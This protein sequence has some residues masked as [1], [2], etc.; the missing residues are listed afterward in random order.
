MRNPRWPNIFAGLVVLAAVCPTPLEAACLTP[1]FF[2]S[3]DASASSYFYTPG[4]C[5][6]GYPCQGVGDTS[7]TADFTGV[8]WRLGSGDPIDGAGID[9]GGFPALDGPQGGWVHYVPSY[10]AYLYSHWAADSRIDGCID[11]PAPPHCMAIALGDQLGGTGYFALLTAAAEAPLDFSFLQPGG[12]PIQLAPLPRP[13]VVASTLTPD[14]ILLTVLPE[15]LPDE[16]FYLDA[17]PACEAEAV[18]G[19]R[20][21]RRTLAPGEPSD[22]ERS[23][24]AWELAG[25]GAG[26]GGAPLPLDVPAEILFDERCGT[27]VLALSLAF[28]SGFETPVVSADSVRIDPDPF[29]TDFDCDGWCGF[30]EAPEIPLDCDD[31]NPDVYPGAPQICDGVNNDCNAPGWPALTYTNEAGE[32]SDG[33]G[34]TGL[35]DNCPLTFNPLQEDIEAD[36]RGDVCDNCLVV[37]NSSQS[38]ADRDGEGDVCDLD[39]ALIYLV[40]AE[41]ELFEWQEESGLGPWNLYRADLEF[42]VE[43]GLYTQ[44]PGSNPLA[45]RECGRAF[46]ALIDMV[47][48]GLRRVAFYLATSVLPVGETDLGLGSDGVVRANANPCP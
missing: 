1:R 8:F 12:A 16:A 43:S 17:T 24:T 44:E 30:A 34:R 35:C 13:A 4:A 23:L 27:L 14:G 20:I 6:G 39:D 26:P 41:S 29:C 11:G 7:V 31:E 5:P 48:P 2:T 36:G 38:D 45:L 40:T 25:G 3:F 42:L 21:Y 9:N 28:D 47:D 15:L 10:P 46:P 19:Y 33:D 18:T 37:R 32:D 22:P